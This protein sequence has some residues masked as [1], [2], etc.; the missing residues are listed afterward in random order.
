VSNNLQIHTDIIQ[1]DISELLAWYHL[2][3]RKL[4]WRSYW[5]ELTS[6][7]HVFLSEFML[8]QTGVSTVIPYFKNFIERW[9]TI[10]NLATASV[11]DVTAAWAGLGYYARAR[12][13]HKTAKIIS[14]Q[15]GVFPQTISELLV[16]P[17]VGPYTAGAIAAFA[18]DK[19]AIVIDGNIERIV[20]RYFNLKTRLPALKSELPEYY[21]KLMPLQKNSDFPQALMD[22]GN[23]FCTSSAPICKDC[24]LNTGCISAKSD[25]PEKLPNRPIKKLKPTRQG[26]IFIL[27]RKQGDISEFLVYR[28]DDKGLLG[29]LLA[30][31]SQ[32]WDDKLQKFDINWRPVK[33]GWITLKPAIKHIFTHFRAELQVFL[34]EY[35]TVDFSSWDALGNAEEDIIKQQKFEWIAENDL[36][37]P[38]L[39]Q[40]SLH[41][42]RQHL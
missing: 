2:A 10:H 38:K 18:F 17:G 42:A 6:A 20:A 31:P 16:L 30:F 13:M 11:D 21:K 28:R 29:G 41:L 33:A 15:G 3:G 35:E 25:N 1:S 32:G 26:Q 36:H 22:L 12:N 23:Q 7:Y 24:P 40:K 4:P 34:A 9:P 39:M 14:Q 37:L 19:P 8:Q 27:R 5:P